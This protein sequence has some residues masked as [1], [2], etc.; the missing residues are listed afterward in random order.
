MDHGPTQKWTGKTGE[1]PVVVLD[2]SGIH[3]L[4]GQHQVAG[5]SIS[6]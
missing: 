2:V 4:V 3:R 6:G 1:P 5:S